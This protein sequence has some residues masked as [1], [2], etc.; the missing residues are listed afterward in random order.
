MTV[1]IQKMVQANKTDQIIIGKMWNQIIDKEINLS[2]TYEMRCEYM[3]KMKNKYRR[4]DEND[5]VMHVDYDDD[6]DEYK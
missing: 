3:K 6:E 2:K 5:V 4:D 1:A